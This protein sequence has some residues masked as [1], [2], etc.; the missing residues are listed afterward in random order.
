L[1]KITGKQGGKSRRL[2]LKPK[3]CIRLAMVWC[4]VYTL[5]IPALQ[6]AV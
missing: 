1:K 4:M 6:W 2:K 5:A 3:R